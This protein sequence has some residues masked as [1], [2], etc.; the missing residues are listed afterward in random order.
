MFNKIFW[1]YDHYKFNI[2]LYTSLETAF[3][4][5]I[6]SLLVIYLI[7]PLFMKLEK[8]IPRLVTVILSIVFIINL[9][10]IFIVK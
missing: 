6:V 4:W 9:I 3:I 10:F 1:N 8:R 5:G 7:H 2:G